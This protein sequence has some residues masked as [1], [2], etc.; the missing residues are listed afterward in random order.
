MMVVFPVPDG[1]TSAATCPGSICET[2]VLQHRLAAVV[3]EV[4][5][6]EFDCSL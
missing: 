6:L 3:A 5:V 2:D 4:H 1:P